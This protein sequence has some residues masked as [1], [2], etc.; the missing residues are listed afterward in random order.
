MSDNAPSHCIDLTQSEIV[1][2]TTPADEAEDEIIFIDNPAPP[3][4]NQPASTVTKRAIPDLSPPGP[5]EQNDVIIVSDQ[6][7]KQKRPTHSSLSGLSALAGLIDTQ[8]K[9]KPL[10]EKRLKRLVA[11]AEQR[12]VIE[13][14][15]PVDNRPTARYFT[16]SELHRL[17]LKN[18]LKLKIG[19][20]I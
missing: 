9:F 11:F 19:G 6:C 7:S 13:I 20:Y 16:N 4:L 3:L 8:T 18:I 10:K 2:S 5:S 15:D 12:N 1:S 14:P 17:V